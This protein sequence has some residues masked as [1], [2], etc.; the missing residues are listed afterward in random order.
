M[1]RSTGH[2]R[3]CPATR[4]NVGIRKC[5]AISKSRR[6]GL[7]MRKFT[8]NMSVKHKSSR[9]M[10]VQFLLMSIFF[11]SLSVMSS[12]YAQGQGNS[13]RFTIFQFHS[14]LLAPFYSRPI[15]IKHSVHSFPSCIPQVRRCRSGFSDGPYTASKGI[16]IVGPLPVLRGLLA[17]I[18][19]S[20]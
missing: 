12:S 20:Y 3:T 18:T 6:L 11:S 1:S 7:R 14:A 16:Y 13:D 8:V 10:T 19:Y 2:V 9:F 5:S 15:S 17:K 4:L